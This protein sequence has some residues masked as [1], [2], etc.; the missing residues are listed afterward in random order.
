MTGTELLALREI[1]PL[2]GELIRLGHPIAPSAVWQILHDA[3][4]G[5]AS[6][7]TGPTWKQFLTT[8]AR[9][10]LAADIVHLDTV[11]LRRIYALIVLSSTAP[12]ASTWP[13]SPGNPTAPGRH[14]TPAF[15]SPGCRVLDYPASSQQEQAM[16]RVRQG[17]CSLTCALHGPGYL[18]P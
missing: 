8:Q 2:P 3:G 11:L 14:R 1:S 16:Q 6:R 4:I 5:A 12:A 15:R 7:R 10:I 13:A 9:S 18:Q 17:T